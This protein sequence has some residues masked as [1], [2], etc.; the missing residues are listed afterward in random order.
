MGWRSLQNKCLHLIGLS[1][2][3]I[4]STLWSG[5]LS[6]IGDFTSWGG[7]LLNSL[8]L[9]GWRV[10]RIFEGFDGCEQFWEFRGFWIFLRVLKVLRV[11]SVKASSYNYFRK[12]QF[13][14]FYNI[15]VKSIKIASTS[16]GGEAD[17]TSS[18]TS[19]GLVV[20]KSPPFHGVKYYSHPLQLRR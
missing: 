2:I 8:R 9:M 7:V 15:R 16:W 1:C 20:L 10:L 13:I 19:S 18:S 3:N 17:K 4:A 12:N 6:K 14:F 5:G 11:L